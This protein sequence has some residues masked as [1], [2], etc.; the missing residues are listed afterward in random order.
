VRHPPNP[1]KKINP[2]VWGQVLK[3]ISGPL[4]KPP[5]GLPLVVLPANLPGKIPATEA[6]LE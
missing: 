2:G 4:L 5:G 6:C 3:K 1:A